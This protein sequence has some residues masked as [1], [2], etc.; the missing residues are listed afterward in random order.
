MSGPLLRRHGK[1]ALAR[2]AGLLVLAASAVARA[3][4]ATYAIDPTHTYVTFEAR[5]FGLSTHRGRFDRTQGTVEFDRAGRSGKAQISVATASV[6]TGVAAL[7]ARLC[8]PDF[9]DCAAQPTAGFAAERFAFDG[10]KVA[11]VAGQLT[12]RG[13]TLPVTLAATRFD[14]YLNLLFLREVCGGD[15]ETTLVLKDWNLGEGG[16]SGLPET[17]RLLIQVE[18]IRQ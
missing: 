6:S 16:A 12:L 10:D 5:H 2:S 15:F 18:A 7:D 1:A 9:L 4:A 17:V 3:D 14:C 11:S 8:A 13:R